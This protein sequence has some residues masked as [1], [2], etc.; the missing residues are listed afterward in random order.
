MNFLWTTFTRF[1]PAADIHAADRRI[2]RNHIAYTGP[3][4]IDARMKPWYPKEL[5][6]DEQTAATVTGALAGILS[7][8]ARRDGRLGAGRISIDVGGCAAVAYESEPASDCRSARARSPLTGPAYN[9]RL[10]S[11]GRPRAV[12]PS[13]VHHDARGNRFAAAGTV[14]GPEH[15]RREAL[16]SVH[17]A[18]SVVDSPLGGHAKGSEAIRKVYDAWVAS[19]PDAQFEAEAPIVDGDR[20]AQVAMVTG[21]DMGGFMGLPPTGKR[22]TMPMVFLIDIKDGKIH[23][24]RRV[25]NFTGTVDSTRRTQSR[26]PP[27]HA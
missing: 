1:E 19:F 15:T 27:D 20:V 18:D 17:A 24:E 16:M 23:H 13:R 5:S 4:V 12:F 11:V 6:C 2:V 21:T 10:I 9:P 22:F 8:G 25:Y 7:V 3:I 14:F 26:N